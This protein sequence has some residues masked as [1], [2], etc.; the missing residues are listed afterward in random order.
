MAVGGRQRAVARPPYST[1]P[2]SKWGVGADVEGGQT[3]LLIPTWTTGARSVAS[4][5]EGGA[6]WAAAGVSMSSSC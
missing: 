5:G 2:R 4:R 1:P 3:R 6:A